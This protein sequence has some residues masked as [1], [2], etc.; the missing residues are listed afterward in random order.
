M[1]Q[2]SNKEKQFRDDNNNN[3]KNVQFKYRM[4]DDGEEEEEGLIV[5]KRNLKKETNKM[6]VANK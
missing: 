4:D 5:E 2:F 3:N 1:N 6:R